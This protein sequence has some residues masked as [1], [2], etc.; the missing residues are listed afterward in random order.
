MAYI[1][2]PQIMALNMAK[3]FQMC[4]LPFIYSSVSFT[5]EVREVDMCVQ[6]E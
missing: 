2:F 1:I 6:G 5:I 3:A 4:H